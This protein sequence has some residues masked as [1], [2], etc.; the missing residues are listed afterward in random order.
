M[1]PGLLTV[2]IVAFTFI[3]PL[4]CHAD[5]EPTFQHCCQLGTTVA[6]QSQKCDETTSGTPV[7]GIPAEQQ[8]ICLST[9]QLC[10]A[11][12]LRDI[13]CKEGKQA[14]T[15]G[16]SC[17]TFKYEDSKYCCEA[18]K[19]GMISGSMAMGCEFREFSLGE[20]WDETYQSCCTTI[21]SQAQPLPPPTATAPP[22]KPPRK[23]H[24]NENICELLKGELCAHICI[25]TG[26]GSYR[27]DC[28]PGFTL[29]GDRKSCQQAK[30]VNR[31]EVNNPCQQHC[32]DTGIAIECSCHSGFQLDTDNK[33]CIDIDECAL[34][35]HDCSQDQECQNELGTFSCKQL[36]TSTT[37][38]SGLST[39]PHQPSTVNVTPFP[40]YNRFTD[41][42]ESNNSISSKGDDRCPF[43]YIFNSATQLCQ[44]VDECDADLH[45]C[46]SGETCVNMPGGY[47]CSQKQTSTFT[48]PACQPGYHYSENYRNCIDIDECVEQDSACDS[49]QLC[50][51]TVGSYQCQCKSGFQLDS[52]T[53]ACVDINEC[54][55]DL[56]NCLPTQR[57]DNTIGS[58]QCVRYTNCGTGY[59]LN[60]QTGLCEDNDEC[61]LRMCDH[62]GPGYKCRNTLGF[63]RCDKITSYGSTTTDKPYD[64]YTT[65]SV[66]CPRG[67]HSGPDR[68]CVDINECE[69]GDIC[70]P[71]QVCVNIAGGYICSNKATCEPGFRLNPQT[72]R[73]V[74]IDECSDQPGLCDHNCLNTWG[75]FRCSC[76][77]GFT[78]STDN[79][80][81]VDINECEVFKDRRL[82][83]GYCVNQP[84][85]YSCQCPQGYRLGLDGA[86]CQDIDECSGSNHC[87]NRN[88]ICLNM[89]GTYR[90][91]S[92]AC[93]TEY[94]KDTQHKNRCKRITMS[95]RDGDTECLEKPLTYTFHFI[96]LVSNLTTRAEGP[97]DLFM[98]RGPVWSSTNVA[99]D[100]QL[101]KVHAPPSVPVATLEDF[102]LVSSDHNIANIRL[103]KPLMGPQD[104]FL[105]LIMKFY[106]NGIYGG[107]TISNISI[108]VSQYEF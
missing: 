67:Y 59:T 102:Q 49:N 11:Q 97:L 35:Q 6:A 75:S 91:V 33:S 84:G 76:R 2:Y 5:L 74:D 47:R 103:L 12:T 61:A 19:L 40:D 4:F 65:P 53:Q 51:N 85:S 73:C 104:I 50:E 71:N 17:H 63:F 27:C 106:Y 24:S 72:N 31:C 90:C 23:Q 26:A 87:T 108:F 64:S 46:N 48:P 32:T 70:K 107:T 41:A 13:Q 45:V 34:D 55:V 95:C 88:E 10:C 57:C 98:M 81:C 96:T 77:P 100:L 105:Q 29:M 37:N 92:T 62:L 80:T 99:F 28:E 54:Q 86:S 1:A 79:R 39:Q 38:T 42:R 94:I 89:R 43:G 68:T 93:P 44:D 30:A 69:R 20:I 60:A 25:P 83:I 78:L 56:H 3:S 22:T 8:S 15:R 101:D 7:Q 16:N 9:M 52:I 36:P 82:C 21:G 66:R 14:A 18:C 58:F